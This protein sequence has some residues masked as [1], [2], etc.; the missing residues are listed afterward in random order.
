MML[1]KKYVQEI[2]KIVTEKPLGTV[3]EIIDFENDGTVVVLDYGDGRTVKKLTCEGIIDGTKWIP[4]HKDFKKPAPG[5]E[6]HSS[7]AGLLEGRT[8]YLKSTE[9]PNDI[10]GVFDVNGTEFKALLKD[11]QA[12]GIIVGKGTFR[13]SRN[14]WV[15]E[16]WEE[17]VISAAPVWFGPIKHSNGNYKLA[18]Y[19]RQ[20]YS[21]LF[22]V[23]HYSEAKLEKS[24]VVVPTAYVLSPLSNSGFLFF[25][26][27]SSVITEEEKL[28]EGGFVS[29]AYVGSK[30]KELEGMFD[31]QS[32]LLPSG[33]PISYKSLLAVFESV[34]TFSEGIGGFEYLLRFE[35]SYGEVGDLQSCIEYF[36]TFVGHS[37][38][39][40]SRNNL[41]YSFAH[42]GSK[43]RARRL[44][45]YD[46][47]E[48]KYHLIPAC[49]LPWMVEVESQFKIPW[50]NYSHNQAYQVFL[51]DYL[52]AE[53]SGLIKG[54]FA[55]NKI[56]ID[57]IDKKVSMA[58]ETTWFDE[59]ITHNIGDDIGAA[60]SAYATAS[61]VEINHLNL[62][63]LPDG[64]IVLF[65]DS[66]ESPM[67]TFDITAAE[68]TASMNVWA[69]WITV[70]DVEYVQNPVVKLGYRVEGNDIDYHDFSVGD[71]IT[72]DM[73]FLN[74]TVQAS[75]FKPMYCVSPPDE[76]SPLADAN[77]Y[78][79]NIM[80]PDRIPTEMAVAVPHI[81]WM[82]LQGEESSETKA[83]Q[84]FLSPDQSAES[85]P[86]VETITLDFS[87]I[88]IPDFEKYKII[89]YLKPGDKMYTINGD[90][91]SID[92]VWDAAK[93]TEYA[94]WPA[95]VY[96]SA[97]MF[98]Q[99]NI[100][101]RLIDYWLGSRSEEDLLYDSVYVYWSEYYWMADRMA[102]FYWKCC[103][104]AW[105]Q[106]VDE[107]LSPPATR[108]F[109]LLELGSD[110]LINEDRL[111]ATV[112]QTYSV[113]RCSNTT[114]T[115]QV[116]QGYIPFA[117]SEYYRR[118]G[119]IA[120]VDVYRWE[121]QDGELVA[122][123]NRTC[124]GSDFA[125]HLRSYG[126]TNVPIVAEDFYYEN[127]NPS[128]PWRVPLLKRRTKLMRGD[129]V[130]A[131]AGGF[132]EHQYFDDIERAFFSSGWEPGRGQFGVEKTSL[133]ETTALPLPVVSFTGSENN[134]LVSDSTNSLV[135]QVIDEHEPFVGPKQPNGIVG[136]ASE[137][138]EGTDDGDC[139][140][141]SGDRRYWERVE[142]FGDYES[143][144]LAN[145]YGIPIY[146]S[147]LKVEIKHRGTEEIYD[148]ID[149]DFPAPITQTPLQTFDN[150]AVMPNPPKYVKVAVRFPILKVKDIMLKDD[151]NMALLNLDKVGGTFTEYDYNDLET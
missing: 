128:L 60:L 88:D 44:V 150:F 58:G 30:F 10:I 6:Q 90:F 37:F 120:E 149:I 148:I 72:V 122:V 126:Y 19:G 119:V 54:V 5:F 69:D 139:V 151:L 87:S 97:T 49:G 133:C 127:Y 95:N 107:T 125:T 56:D 61:P 26:R 52:G 75:P 67:T 103:T 146:F 105:V 63:K 85:K 101:F 137:Y 34:S 13:E 91:L 124:A 86:N 23:S 68:Y 81:E 116:N 32:I 134:I 80:L 29:P 112:E 77:G 132:I 48:E 40:A 135:Q 38:N 57:V 131:R 45:F 66:W 41:A 24:R 113:V 96:T 33:A 35:P 43:Y 42:M 22:T 142:I 62:D 82:S 12:T 25:D 76:V 14:P 130:V 20:K 70:D 17:V 9:G 46:P 110:E 21:D 138:I 53:S 36:G 94:E 3:P 64:K 98:V 106:S 102:H 118:Y 2:Y 16:P 147:G 15:L 50:R 115:T 143:P 78:Y 59:P 8:G 89:L 136:F 4:L 99:A 31:I 111:F 141:D 74:V 140:D 73:H 83:V 104:E 109:P 84:S 145:L 7:G 11:P 93:S 39:F 65:G 1:D 92:Y 114:K 79:Y 71:D 18:T 100:Q 47:T 129:K 27:F 144:Q 117:I 123:F 51:R 108:M 28:Y 55:V 121:L